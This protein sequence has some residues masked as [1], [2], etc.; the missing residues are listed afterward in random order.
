MY[1]GQLKGPNKGQRGLVHLPIRPQVDPLPPPP[2]SLYMST[3]T[4]EDGETGLA[5]ADN[6]AAYLPQS[7][8]A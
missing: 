5:S 7:R 3:A 1:Q 6:P 2:P 4:A 8:T